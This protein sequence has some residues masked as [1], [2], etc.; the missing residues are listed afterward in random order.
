[1][2]TAEVVDPG[3]FSCFSHVPCGNLMPRGVWVPPDTATSPERLGK[4]LWKI[5]WKKRK[6]RVF[7]VTL[8]YLLFGVNN[9]FKCI[10]RMRSNGLRI[11]C[12]RLA[13]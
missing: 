3:G 5:F 13:L 12:T 11:A 4:E 10:K 8:C 9:T 2:C 7:R 1:M 6:L